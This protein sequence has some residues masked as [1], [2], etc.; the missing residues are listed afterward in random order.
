MKR[1]ST[2]RDF[3]GEL[4]VTYKRTSKPTAKIKSSI[5][6]AAFARPLFDEVMDNHEEFKI[7]HLNNNNDV[8]NVHHVSKGGLTGTLVDIRIVAREAL[9]IQCA[10][11]C[12][13]HNHPS[14]TLKASQ[15]D[16][17]ISKKI[18]KALA[19]FD[20]K[21]LDHVIMTREGYLSL[22]DEGLF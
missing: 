4:T 9:H 21:V 2:Y 20:I 19:L 10:G 8:V 7:L 17:Y 11:V 16:I 3:L 22:K 13:L 18:E 5:D 1:I 15:P 14:G 12:L 6:V